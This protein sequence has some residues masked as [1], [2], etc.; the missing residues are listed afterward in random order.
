MK[1]VFIRVVALFFAAALCTQGQVR[2][3]SPEWPAVVA[4]ARGQT[5]YWHAYAGDERVNR[6]IIWVADEVRQRY[7]IE[8]HHVKVGNIKET[9]GKVIAASE[10][11][12]VE[13]VDLMWLNGQNFAALKERKLLFGPITHVLPHF[14]LVDTV[15]KPT[16][17]VDYTV[18]TQGLE[19]PWG[20][21]QLV[22]FADS[23][24]V[25]QPPRTMAALRAWA[26]EHPGRLT[27]P[28]PPD[29]TGITF[30]KQAL[31]ESVESRDVIYRPV[32]EADFAR[33][34]A[35]LWR[36]MDSLHPY[37]WQGGKS[38][39]ATYP[40][41]RKM[42]NDGEIDIGFSFNP[43]EASGAAAQK[44]LP[45]TVQPFVLEGGT[46]GNTHFVA[47]PSHAM[48]KEG[49]MVVA[50]FLLTPEAQSRKSNPEI[51]GES[52]VLDLD[53]L[54]RAERQLFEDLP[55]GRAMPTAA[56]LQRVVPEPHPS[57][58]IR[59]AEE[60]RLRYGP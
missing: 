9:V 54:T 18:P 7:G 23:A 1:V 42:I 12:V 43:A 31:L 3:S 38:F 17:L 40:M 41:M 15:H 48:A 35:P 57:W 58:T 30:L 50:D 32:R 14:A 27:Y 45:A 33:V 24:R 10:G 25:K 46:I 56:D 4:R 19:S 36:Y 26:A 22:F 2:A 44:L 8:L 51:W 53:K 29:F 60:W 16:T 55:R 47:I 37:L 59:I 6:Y 13:P 11:A 52:T 5:V 34:T 49:A 39:P 20:M 28:A 21:A